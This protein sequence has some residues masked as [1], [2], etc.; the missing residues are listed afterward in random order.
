MFVTKI[1]LKYYYKGS[2]FFLPAKI[3]RK[4]KKSNGGVL[5][6]MLI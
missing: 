6:S 4:Y 1:L 5:K 2:R 3:L